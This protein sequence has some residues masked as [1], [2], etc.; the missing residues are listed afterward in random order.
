MER[1]D[2]ISAPWVEDPDRI[3]RP[4][5]VGAGTWS[6]VRIDDDRALAHI[7]VFACTGLIA[8]AI[9]MLPWA[10]FRNETTRAGRLVKH[11][12]PDPVILSDPAPGVGTVNEIK[13]QIVASQLLA[14]DTFNIVGAVNRLGIPRVMT[15]LAPKGI[16]RVWRDDDGRRRYDLTDGGSL[17]HWADLSADERASGDSM[18]HWRGYTR[19]GNLRGLSPIEA[20]RQGIGLSIAAEKF[21]ATWFGEGAIPPSILSHPEEMDDDEAKDAQRA[22]VEAR[23]SRHP[24]VLSGGLEFETIEI[25]PEESQFIETRKLSAL[26]I[27]QLYRI[28]PHMVGLVDRSTSWGSGIE[29]QAIGFVQ[30]TL[31]PWISRLEAGMTSLL[32]ERQYVKITT[33]ALLRG[34]IVERF[35]AYAI[36][37][38]WGWLSV[39]DIRA[40]EDEPP[41]A[42]GDT[43]LQ[44]LNMVDATKALE[45]I[46]KDEAPEPVATSTEGDT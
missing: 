44:P 18:L 33:N 17:T 21:G 27:A 34:R 6:G 38:Q 7:P 13:F 46:M 19:A 25:S 1:R 15:P 8:D 2:L 4:S 39:N 9:A 32:P 41:I 11:R 43:Y 26:D 16:R 5:E 10:R 3:P 40:L 29:E 36:G 20:G 37:R 14:G 24:A 28:P 23:R 31:G 45:A 12:L 30:Y 35:K 22:W 42:G